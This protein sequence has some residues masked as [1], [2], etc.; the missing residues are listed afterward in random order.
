LVLV[1]GST[2]GWTVR[3]AELALE[4]AVV[5]IKRLGLE[6]FPEKYEAMWFCQKAD[7]GTPPADYLLRLVEAEI[8]VG[9]SMRYLGLTLDSHWT[10][11]AHFERLITSV[12]ATVN[13][14]ERLR[15]R[16]SGPG[17]GMRQLYAGVMRAKILYGAPI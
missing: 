6:V 7:Y 16:L 2:W 9:T 4:C 11:G 12:D 14:L 8:G 17:V 10:F 1:W 3:L 13:V 15:L 5:A